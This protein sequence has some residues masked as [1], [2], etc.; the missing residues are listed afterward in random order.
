VD[1][2]NVQLPADFAVGSEFVGTINYDSSTAFDTIVSPDNAIYHFTD[3]Y[4]IHVTIGGIAVSTGGMSVNVVNS[5]LDAVNFRDGSFKALGFDDLVLGVGLRD[6]S[7]QALSDK[8][9][10]IFLTLDQFP[11]R[12]EFFFFDWQGSFEV[13]GEVTYLSFVPEPHTLL[14]FSA[15][16]LLLLTRRRASMRR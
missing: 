2:P 4:P 11:D 8:S 14:L 10:P 7:A 1:D 3:R 6:L 13:L 16:G 12:R 9:L 15:G 5:T